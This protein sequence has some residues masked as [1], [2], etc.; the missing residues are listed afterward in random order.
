MS[1]HHIARLIHGRI[2]HERYGRIIATAM[3]VLTLFAGCE[4]K[5]FV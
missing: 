1:D 2:V 4:E 5:V 3:I